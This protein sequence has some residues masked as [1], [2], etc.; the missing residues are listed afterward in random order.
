MKLPESH[1][2]LQL[3]ALINPLDFYLLANGYLLTVSDKVFSRTIFFPEISSRRLSLQVSGHT[4]I[5]QEEIGERP[6]VTF[7]D[8]TVCIQWL[9]YII[10]PYL[11]AKRQSLRLE[12]IF[13]DAR[14]YLLLINKSR[15]G[16][17]P[18]GIFA[19]II[20]LKETWGKEVCLSQSFG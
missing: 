17:L 9:I 15:I 4:K 13:L 16:E 12:M 19:I 5:V 10:W 14:I 2:I 11:P 20:M 7:S 6:S 1:D 18:K 3:Y 8:N